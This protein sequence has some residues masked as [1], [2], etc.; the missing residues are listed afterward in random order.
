MSESRIIAIPTG[1]LT[2]SSRV[3]V[4]IVSDETIGL[5]VRCAY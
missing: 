4:T 1:K 3:T 5:I 2:A